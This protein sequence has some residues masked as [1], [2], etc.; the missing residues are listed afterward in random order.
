MRQMKPKI[1][2]ML[3]FKQ[4]ADLWAYLDKR[5]KPSTLARAWQEYFQRCRQELAYRQKRSD[6]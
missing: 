3:T 6:E 1:L 4:R 2:A 5:K